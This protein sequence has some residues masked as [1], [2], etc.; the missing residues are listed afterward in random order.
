MRFATEQDPMEGLTYRF[1]R[2]DLDNFPQAHGIVKGDYKTKSVYYTNSCQLNVSK[3]IDPIEKIREEGLFH[4]LIEAGSMTHLWIGEQKPSPKSIANLVKK[5]FFETTNSLIAFSPE[6]TFC[7]DCR[8]T[9]RGLVD[10][11]ST[12]GSEKVDHATRVSGFYSLTSRWNKG[13]IQEL[14][15]RYR[16]KNKL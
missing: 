9:T 10:K 5:T 2:L 8:A 1:A 12:C 13:K 7:G 6:F 14:K 16:N 15:E 4:P 11:C 3:E